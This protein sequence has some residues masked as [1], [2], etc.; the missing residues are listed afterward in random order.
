MSAR[1]PNDAR[2]WAQMVEPLR[3]AG[4]EYAEADILSRQ[5]VAL[6]RRERDPQRNT[7]APGDELPDPPP[8]QVVDVD[9]VVWEHQ[10]AGHGM[11][12]MS[13]A[14]Q[15]DLADSTFDIQGVRPWPF[16]LDGE[17]P[18]TELAKSAGQ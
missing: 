3:K 13:A 14:D 6:V 15:R 4:H 17:G 2:L 1:K 5:L 11:Y 18:L 12:R 10:D 9:G 7:Y 16:L 8:A